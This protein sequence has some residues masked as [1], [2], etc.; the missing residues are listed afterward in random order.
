MRAMQLAWSVTMVA[1]KGDTVE[2]THSAEIQT[3]SLMTIDVSWSTVAQCGDVSVLDII[4][5][6][7][8]Q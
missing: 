4:V 3:V 7:D 6:F 5:V 1:E 8:G 2:T